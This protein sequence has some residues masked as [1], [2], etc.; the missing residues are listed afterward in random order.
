MSNPGLFHTARM[1][2]V[3]PH[4]KQKETSEMF[5]DY[6]ELL[7]VADMH[8]ITGLSERTIRAELTSG[9]LPGCRIGRRLFT[10]KK[11]FI[12]FVNGRLVNE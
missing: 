5:G 11:A 10:P 8:N 3:T 7:T 4:T 12:E 6:P 9:A 2:Q 1:V